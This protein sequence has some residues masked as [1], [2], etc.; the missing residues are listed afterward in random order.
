MAT[1]DLIIGAIQ[2]KAGA[3]SGMKG[4][5]DT[6][7]ESINQF[8]FSVCYPGSGEWSPQSAGWMKGLHTII[9]EIHVSRAD[10]STGVAQAIPY[11]QLFAN[12]LLSDLR[13]N[14]TVDT[15]RAIR[16]SFARLQWGGSGESHLGWKF[17]VDVK[18]E[19][20]YT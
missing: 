1:L 15:V 13:L 20:T 18:V 9:C 4:A 17:E 11:G 12:A 19:P 14:N 10:L 2:D 16:Y 6:P 8:P 5:P 3:L 7:P